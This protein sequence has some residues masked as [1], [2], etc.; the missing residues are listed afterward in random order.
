MNKEF[1]LHSKQILEN[2]WQKEQ[3]NWHTKMIKE[4]QSPM[5]HLFSE[6][7]FKL[8]KSDKITLPKEKRYKSELRNIR[9]NAKKEL[10]S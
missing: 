10:M 4:A 5:K 1:H 2:R 7:H 9:Y 8:I 3:K 6:N